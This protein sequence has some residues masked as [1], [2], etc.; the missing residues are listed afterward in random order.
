MDTNEN[1]MKNQFCSY[2]IALLLKELGFNEPCL[3]VFRNSILEQSIWEYS[4]SKEKAEYILGNN[5]NIIILAPLWQQAINWFREKYSIHIWIYYDMILENSY[6]Q[7]RH[8]ISKNE[9]A[10]FTNEI[11]SNKMNEFTYEQS[12]EQSI[13][14]SLELCQEIK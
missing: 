1:Y 10:H 14:K 8:E 2:E 6:Y 9:Y 3:A 11:E 7:I 12:R 13:L 4:K 5:S